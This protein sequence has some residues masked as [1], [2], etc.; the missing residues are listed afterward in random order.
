MDMIQNRN[1][2]SHTYNDAVSR[3]IVNNIIRRY[4]L[5]FV[6]LAK[7]LKQLAKVEK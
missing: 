4:Y 3:K 6:E 7:K 2:T 1:E 5:E